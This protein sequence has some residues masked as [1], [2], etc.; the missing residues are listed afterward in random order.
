MRR[1]AERLTVT[2]SRAEGTEQTSGAR[3]GTEDGAGVSFQ[4]PENVL[5][6]DSDGCTKCC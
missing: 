3:A 6:L 2:Q 5:K 1:P 4:S